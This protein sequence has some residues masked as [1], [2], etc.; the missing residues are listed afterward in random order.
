MGF[1]IASPVMAQKKGV[2]EAICL[3]PFSYALQVKTSHGTVSLKTTGKE[4]NQIR[5]ID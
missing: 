3:R 5:G 1:L 2:N 4:T